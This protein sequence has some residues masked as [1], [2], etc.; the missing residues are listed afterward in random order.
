MKQDWS[1]LAGIFDG[2]G[3][4][5]IAEV[6]MHNTDKY[7]SKGYRVDIHITNTSV[8]LVK[9]LVSNFGGVYYTVD[10]KNPNWKTAYR[11]VP[12]GKKNKENFFLGILPYL[13]IKRD[14][15]LLCLDF[16]RL[17]GQCPDVRKDLCDRARLLTQRG[18]SV[19]TNTL[20]PEEIPDKIESDLE[21]DFKSVPLVTTD[22]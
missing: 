12:K 10:M 1:Y 3:C 22:T 5:H 21:G 18:K 4:A 9:W 2:E 11:W 14:I 17:E 13:I 16:L 15:S 8:A 7:V 19:T 6:D 20:G